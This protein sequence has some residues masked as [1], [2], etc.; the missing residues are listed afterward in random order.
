MRKGNWKTS[1]SVAAMLAAQHSVAFGLRFF[2]EL[3]ENPVTILIELILGGGKEYRLLDYMIFLY[4]RAWAGQTPSFIPR[5]YLQDQFDKE[6]GNPWRWPENFKRAYHI[7][8]ALPEP[9]NQVRADINSAGITIYP[10]PVGTT[11]FE[12]HPKIAY[13]KDPRRLDS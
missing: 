4:W 3:Q 6:D 9:I 11:F 2:T 7:M 1:Q 5:R 13:R 12:G 8:K 10:F